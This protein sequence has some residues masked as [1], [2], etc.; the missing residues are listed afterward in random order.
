MSIRIAA[1][2]SKLSLAQVSVVANYLQKLGYE[3]SFIEVKT[4]ADLFYNEPLHKL[5]KG[6]FEKEVNEFVLQGKADLAVHS[7]KDLTSFLDPNL[8]I[9]AVVKRDSPYD[10]LVANKNL[11]DLEEK[12]VIGTSSIRRQNFVKFFRNDLEV[13]NL[14]GNIDTRIGK[15]EKGEYDGIIIAEASITRLKLNVKYYRLDYFDFTP[16]ANQGI[17]AVIG[18]KS[19][20][21]LKKLLSNL[22]DVDTFEEAL[23]ERSTV[24][25]VGGGCHSPFGVYFEKHDTTFMGV[26]SFSNSKK[27]ITV[28]IE[29]RGDP[30][31]IG[32]KL[33]KILLR[34]MKSENIIP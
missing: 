13:K 12:S 6:V 34:E 31:E 23:A 21:E 32:S 10:V 28:S 2:G 4:K 8:E 26:A 5:G 20:I 22:N 14:R 29:E 9:L 18:R 11:Y 16:E 19:D 30:K 15:Y 24:Q 3:T 33:G 17:I 7:M 1:R 27:K 25:V